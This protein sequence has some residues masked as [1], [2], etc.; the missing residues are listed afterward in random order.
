MTDSSDADNIKIHSF[1]IIMTN[2]KHD[3]LN[4]LTQNIINQTRDKKNCSTF[5]F[6]DILCV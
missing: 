5:S 3:L 2:L 4:L 1:I 6:I